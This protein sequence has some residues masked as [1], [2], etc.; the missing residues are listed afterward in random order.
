MVKLSYL[1]GAFWDNKSDEFIHHVPSTVIQLTNLQSVWRAILIGEIKLRIKIGWDEV[2]LYNR[3]ILITDQMGSFTM[4]HQLQFSLHISTTWTLMK[5]GKDFNRSNKKL[6]YTRSSNQES[7]TYTE[8]MSL[9]SQYGLH[10][11]L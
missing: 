4:F 3:D 11:S 7:Q 8:L 5:V 10:V 1:M 2:E 9:K 6:E